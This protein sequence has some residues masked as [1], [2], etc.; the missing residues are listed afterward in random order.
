MILKNFKNKDFDRGTSK[1]TECIWLFISSLLISSWI[2]GSFWRAFILKIFGAK[3]GSGVIFKPHIRIKF[4]WRLSIG[5][6][7]WIGEFVWIDN[8]GIVSIGN[9]VCIS[10]GAYLCTGSHNWSAK[11]F[12]LLV[13]PIVIHNEVWVGAFSRI[14]P[15]SILN[16]G[17]VISLGITYTGETSK[18]STYS[19]PKHFSIKIR[20]EF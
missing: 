5:N 7:C 12:D 6:N 13:S 16:E 2:P 17:S 19:N 1:I 11:S 14:G 8:L 18:W 20:K 10:Q 3:I 4:P 9:N 15:G